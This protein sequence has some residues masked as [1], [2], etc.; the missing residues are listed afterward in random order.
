[1]EARRQL[2]DALTAAG[3]RAE[4]VRLRLGDVRAL[5]ADRLRGRP[6]R[7][8]FRT[9][10]LTMCTMVPMRSVPH[11][12]VVLLG[13]DD[14]V[15]PRS[16]R[17]DGDDVLGRAP[18]VGERDPRSEDR[19]LFLDA[20]L[21]A[22]ERLVV[23]YSGAD[24]RTGAVRPP[25]VPLGELLDVVA[26]MLPRPEDRERVLVRHP[27]QPFDGR[28]F[29][30]GA[31]G[32]PGPFSFDR[33]SY[34]G[35]RAMRAP[36]RARPAFLAGP[37]AEPAPPDLVTLHELVEFLEAPV[38]GFLRQRLDL[39]L[40][41]ELE[42]QPDA[43]ALE[44]GPLERWTVG[45]RVLRSGLAGVGRA[46]V[47]RAERLRGDLPPGA[48][49]AAV[50]DRVADEV[51]VLVGRTSGLRAGPA[52]AVDVTVDLP[53]GPRVAG[54]VPGVRGDRVVRVE[55]SRLG[56]KHRVRAWIQL[57]ALASGRPGPAWCAATV[58]RG[59]DGPVM[60]AL[61]A[62]APE[63]ALELLG[64]LA[65]LRVAGLREPLPLAPRSS[66]GY[67]EVRA[68][69]GPPRA[70][71]ARAAQQWRTSR[72]EGGAFGEFDDAAH[73]RVWGEVSLRHLLRLGGPRPGEPYA[74]EPHRFGQLA[75]QVFAPLLEH[76]AMH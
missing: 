7:A 18:L 73:V 46:E 25:A 36:R 37:L 48:L 76:E 59:S 9:G 65:R 5:L 13:L 33:A 43:I 66:C 55:Y 4:T 49:G 32:V 21:A 45:D 39:T 10:H 30:A 51:E 56:A 53:G 62:P 68:R 58:G 41:R 26:G 54:T 71:E 17:L 75:R 64:T 15:F 42:E 38:R 29:S 14:G 12:V 60:S 74:D 47:V 16:T 27:L 19:Q 63:R 1:V 50:L 24:E 67:A 22:G 72:R 34:A 70:A 6:T 28:A 57:L 2:T 20:V 11:R 23:L 31:L 69:G 35:A 61:A 3:S 8:G 52:Q 40:L 44:T